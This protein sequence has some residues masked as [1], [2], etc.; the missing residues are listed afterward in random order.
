MADNSLFFYDL[1]TTGLHPEGSRIMQ[2]AGQRTDLSLNPIGS[3]INYLISLTPDILPDPMA[4]LV[5]GISPQQTILEGISE[6][7]FLNIFYQEIVK[8]NTTFVG[9]NNIRFDDEF[10]RYLNYRNLYDPYSWSYENN[11][12]RWDI[13]DLVRITRAL[14]P[15][16][17]SW[18]IDS[19]GKSVNRLEVLTK[20]NN[21]EHNQAHDAYSDV[22]ATIDVANLIRQTQPKLYDYIFSLRS[23]TATATLVNSAKPFVYTSSH[24]QA[25]NQYTTV[26]IKVAEHPKPNCAL[27]YDLRYD[28]TPWLSMSAD[29]L[30]AAWRFKKDKN[31]DDIPFPVK[32]VRLN[33][34]PAIAPLSVLNDSKVTNP[35]NLNLDTIA[36]HQAVLL[37]ANQSV[38]AKELVRAVQILDEEQSVRFKSKNNSVDTRMYDGFYFASDRE[39]F[40]QL[41]DNES[42]DTVRTLMP[43]FSDGRLKELASLYL[44]RNFPKELTLDERKSWDDYLTKQLFSGGENSQL[45]LYFQRLQQLASERSDS[46]SQVLLEDLKLY[47]ESLI[48]SDIGD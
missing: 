41:H 46:K 32:T 1:E 17:I 39:L 37:S 47:G 21:L 38:F 24:Y 34:C 29:Q 14:R 45:A 12:S 22:M 7:E 18:P 6:L 11:C 23:K 15:D 5:H 40:K 48:P 44:A 28:P 27:V 31:E 43:V 25:A 9:F 33:R 8:P 19:K 3:P 36:K 42:A 2:F 26:V 30:V 4:I 20:E 10:M 35:L 16:G 13:L